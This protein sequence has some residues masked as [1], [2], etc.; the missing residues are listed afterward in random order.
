[1]EEE[2][3]IKMLE[4]EVASLEWDI[5]YYK[6]HGDTTE[7]EEKEKYI[8]EVLSDVLGVV[9]IYIGGLQRK[10]TIL[11]SKLAGMLNKTL[12]DDILSIEKIESAK[13]RLWRDIE[14]PNWIDIELVVK[15]KDPEDNYT[16]DLMEEVYKVLDD[17]LGKEI[18]SM[19]MLYFRR[20]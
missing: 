10:K 12:R 11:K 16:D 3:K 17:N 15:T 13:F 8:I 19:I 5:K 1:M 2:N 9:D 7:M 4:G 20:R 14:D 18:S 6:A